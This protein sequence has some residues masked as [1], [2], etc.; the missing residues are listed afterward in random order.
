[1]LKK[2]KKRNLVWDF[3]VQMDH[4]ISARRSNPVLI[5]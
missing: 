3:E 1:M 4:L 2:K 5:N